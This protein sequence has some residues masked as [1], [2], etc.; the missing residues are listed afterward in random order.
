M[1]PLMMCS[2]RTGI[3]VEYMLILFVNQTIFNDVL[4]SFYV[5]RVA[6][7]SNHAQMVYDQLTGNTMTIDKFINIAAYLLLSILYMQR[8][9]SKFTLTKFAF[10]LD[11]SGKKSKYYV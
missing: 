10:G 8:P 5:Y 4:F 6:S 11:I 3:F 1:V 7:D 9:A 2:S